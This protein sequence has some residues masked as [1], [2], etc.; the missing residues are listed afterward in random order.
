MSARDN[1]RSWEYAAEFRNELAKIQKQM[2]IYA[3]ALGEIAG[4]ALKK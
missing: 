2:V 1:E 4:V 3:T